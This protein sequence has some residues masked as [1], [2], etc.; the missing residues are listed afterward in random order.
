MKKI[1]HNIHGFSL[2]EITVATAVFGSIVLIAAGIFQ[3]AAESQRSALAS[4]NI[5]ESLSYALEVISKEIR[6]AVKNNINCNL[7]GGISNNIFNVIPGGAGLYFANKNKDCVFYRV[8]NGRL[9]I[10]RNAL[11]FPLTP[12]EI[13]V[14]SINFYIKDNPYGA[15]SGL[16]QPAVSLV[17]DVEANYGIN[18]KQT[19]KIQTSLSSRYYEQAD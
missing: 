8:E 5:Q 15:V 19:M 3:M 10:K 4:Q 7:G 13:K 14:N 17:L 18:K 9:M 11:D 1:I 16:I 2:L 12:D 6:S